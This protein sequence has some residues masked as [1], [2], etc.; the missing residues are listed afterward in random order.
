MQKVF[1]EIKRRKK[2]YLSYKR[3]LGTAPVQTNA[4]TKIPVLHYYEVAMLSLAVN[5]SKHILRDEFI[6]NSIYLL[7]FV[8]SSLAIIEVLNNF[9]CYFVVPLL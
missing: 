8:A 2:L 9:N 1:L 7:F 3:Q 5:T 6:S 4:I